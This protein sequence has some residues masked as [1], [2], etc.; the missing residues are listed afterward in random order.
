MVFLDPCAAGASC[1]PVRPGVWHDGG[2]NLRCDPTR[3]A[4]RRFRIRRVAALHSALATKD[5]LARFPFLDGGL[6]NA[7]DIPS[8]CSD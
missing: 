8:Q 6:P 3:S 1:S 4:R 7:A 5:F 2:G